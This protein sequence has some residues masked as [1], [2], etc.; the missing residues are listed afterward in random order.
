V[1]KTHLT[2]QAKG[3]V[4][5]MFS[6]KVFDCTNLRLL[7]DLLLDPFDDVR[8][9]ALTIL[10]LNSNS[11]LEDCATPAAYLMHTNTTS[12]EDQSLKHS[13]TLERALRIMHKTG[14]MDHADGVARIYDLIN[15]NQRVQNSTRISEEASEHAFVL[16]LIGT[17]EKSLHLAK[18]AMSEAVDKYPVHGLLIGL[19]CYFNSF[20]A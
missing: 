4:Q 13:E 14:R 6:L 9:A 8:Q 1:P 11:D 20:I 2:R 10:K 12:S 16:Q 19:R 7:Y 3:Q 17:I 18:V 5:W 15:Y